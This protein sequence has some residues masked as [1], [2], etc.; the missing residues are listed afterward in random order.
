MLL[1]RELRLREI[2]L[3]D[4]LSLH[5]AGQAVVI[6]WEAQA[7][8][9]R[10]PGPLSRTFRPHAHYGQPVRGV[11]QT[12]ATDVDWQIFLQTADHDLE[13]AQKILALLDRARDAVQELELTELTALAPLA[14]FALGNVRGN[15]AYRVHST[16]PIV[17]SALSRDVG[18]WPVILRGD[19]LDLQGPAG[20]L[21]LCIDP[22]KGIRRLLREHII[23]RFSEDG[24]AR[25]MK[26][27]LKTSIDQ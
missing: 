8:S 1:E 19:L 26:Q 16:R 15:A 9:Q 20:R 17:Q 3:V 14:L 13:D 21:D 2:R 7:L 12:C 4:H 10:D 23:V 27:L 18:V 6:D 22:P 11:V 5:A 25:V 24:L